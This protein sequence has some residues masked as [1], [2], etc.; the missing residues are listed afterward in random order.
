MYE[1]VSEKNGLEYF[2]AK[3]LNFNL[4][5]VYSFTVTVTS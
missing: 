4:P 3:K 5:S 1:S 2:A